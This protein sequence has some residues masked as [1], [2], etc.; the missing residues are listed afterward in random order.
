[1]T[2]ITIFSAPKPFLD[3]HISTIQR[4]AIRSWIEL[5]EQ[6][7]VV[8]LGNESGLQQAAADLNVN[9]IPRVERNERGTPL[10]SSLF[11]LARQVNK[12]E[13]MFYV[14]A[15]IILLP[16]CL[17][18]IGRVHQQID[19]YLL[20]GR[21]WDLEVKQELSFGNG[22]SERLLAKT[23]REGRLRGHT[24]MDYFIFPRHLYQE[25]P[26]FAVG[27]AG[28]D[29][30]MIYQAFQQSWPVINTTAAFPVIHQNHDYSHLP[31]GKPHYDLE[32]SYRNVDLGG[33]ISAQ[34]DLLDVDLEFRE[35]RI[36]KVRLSLSR[37]LRKIERLVIPDQ[38]TGWRWQLTRLLRKT[39]RRLRQR[40]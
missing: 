14:N 18:V 22:W 9:I 1:M 35:G 19:N 30:W 10:I 13:I 5:G 16:Q 37:F 21:R 31:E 27:R 15:D 8:L 12:N 39:R 7:D 33:G 32:E 23:S 11:S 24:A 26:P 20:V 34:F 28:W 38:Q 6:A 2:R 4:N 17:P 40:R 25:I 3:P 29:N 36:Q